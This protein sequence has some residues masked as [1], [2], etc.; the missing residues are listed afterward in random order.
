MGEFAIDG[1]EPNKHR[2]A[3]RWILSH[4]RRQ[5]QLF[6][7]MFFGAFG[8]AALA[9]VMPILIG[10][11]FD[12]ALAS[13]PN[14][15]TIGMAALGIIASQTLRAILQLGR[16]FASSVIGERLERDTRHELYVSLLGK[17]MTFHDLQ[18]VGD[19]MARATNDVRELNLMMYPG[20][21]LVVGSA[22]FMIMPLLVAP[23]YHWQLMLA[24]LF[25]IVTYVLALSQYMNVLARIADRVRLTFGVLN[26]RLAEAIDGIEMVKSTAQEGA[27]VERFA[28]NAH[29]FRDATVAQGR[30][31]AKF[32]PLLLLGITEGIGFAHAL[33]LLQ[34]GQL[35]V[36]DVVA[37]MGL[38]SLFGFPTNISLMAYS[39]VSLGMAGARRILELINSETD[40]HEN[41]DGYSEPIEGEIRFENVTFGYVSDVD[42]LSDV[43]FSV[44]PG[45]TVAVVG[46][47]GAG[48]STLTKLINRTYDVNEG[49]VLVDGVDVR[50]WSLAALRRQISIIEQDIFLF[51]RT[52]AQN[53]AFGAP[54]ATR[55][56]IEAAARAAQAHE[57]I[58]GFE[59]GYE[60]V[61]GER[62][63]TLSG[64]QR[65]R[66]ALARAF[67]THPRILILDDSTSAVDSETEDQIQRAIRHA[68]ENRTTFLIT[69]RLSQIRWADLVLVLRKGRLEA[70][71]DHLTL[72]ETSPAYRLIF[73]QYELSNS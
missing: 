60:T 29:A 15:N 40:L 34:A 8:N 46:Q 33:L 66:I 4:L 68:S 73:D 22:N 70:A 41:P 62:G 25:F 36:G 20:I 16:N 55:E 11:A 30:E 24:P 2:S 27:E 12:A 48:K 53:I 13:P 1:L 7:V 39:R 26:A 65:Q 3:I 31:E 35:Q 19:T 14:L 42:V 59:D 57:F 58:L 56:A 6:I 67:L 37:Y 17:S 69:H 45:Q 21:N 63:V 9:A 64:G 18:P 50:D 61:V 32:L 10:I 52:V 47:T 5:W 28:H 71:G 51:S 38:L 54:E 44:R 43:S 49:R 23:R 72:M